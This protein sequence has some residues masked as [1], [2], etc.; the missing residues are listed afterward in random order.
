MDNQRN[1]FWNMG[2]RLTSRKW[3]LA[4]SACAFFATKGEAAYDSITQIVIA[5][6]AVQAV[7][8]FAERRFVPPAPPTDPDPAPASEPEDASA[9][10]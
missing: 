4:L 9:G 7:T 5:F 1:G 2:D 3:L 6:L 10:D 8:D